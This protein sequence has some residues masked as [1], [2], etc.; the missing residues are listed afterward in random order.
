MFFS[1]SMGILGN[2]VKLR[3]GFFSEGIIGGL[4]RCDCFLLFSFSFVDCSMFF[5]PKD[6]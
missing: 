4:K 2:W 3:G 6:A 1:F 5:L